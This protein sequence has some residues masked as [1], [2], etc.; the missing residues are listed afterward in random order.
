MLSGSSIWTCINVESSETSSLCIYQIILCTIDEE[1]KVRDW[2]R[3]EAWWAACCLLCETLWR[4]ELQT[5]DLETDGGVSRVWGGVRVTSPSHPSLRLHSSHP[6]FI[7]ILKECVNGLSSSPEI[8]LSN[9]T[10]TLNRYRV[11]HK[12]CNKTFG[13]YPIINHILLFT[14][15][16]GGSF[17]P[18]EE[19][20]GVNDLLLLHFVAALFVTE[21]GVVCSRH[22]IGQLWGPQRVCGSYV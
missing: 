3:M 14:L 20:I 11:S 9:H 13:K 18:S 5:Q 4:S 8:H 21:H 12:A 7:Y 6:L 16:G 1:S 17:D 22:L 2:W 19:A 10:K 15:G